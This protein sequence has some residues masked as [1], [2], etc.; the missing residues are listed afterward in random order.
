MQKKVILALEDAGVFTSGGLVKDK[1]IN[2][3]IYITDSIWGIMIFILFLLF[4]IH[5]CN[6]FSYKFELQDP[7]F[8]CWIFIFFC[9][10]H[11]SPFILFFYIFTV[12]FIFCMQCSCRFSFVAQ[13]MDEHLLFDNWNQIGILT[14]ILI[15]FSS[16][17]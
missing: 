6:Y 1:V 2:V 8:S 4:S 10:P 16:W 13:K 17:R 12:Y 3:N 7:T 15:S 11:C 5:Y 14:Q 9:S